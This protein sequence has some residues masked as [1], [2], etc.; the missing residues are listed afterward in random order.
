LID[1]NLEEAKMK[2]FGG[3]EA[4]GT[5]FVC[6]VGNGPDQLVEEKRFPTTTPDETIARVIE[7]FRSMPIGAN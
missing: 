5:K 1:L 7:F 3:I 2:L 4:G 6:L